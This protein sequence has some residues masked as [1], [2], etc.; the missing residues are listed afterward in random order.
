MINGRWTTDVKQITAHIKVKSTIW[1]C[2][3]DKTPM[4]DGFKFQVLN[5]FWSIVYLG[6]MKFFRH[7]EYYG[8]LGHGCNSSFITLASES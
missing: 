8:S 7:F 5:K 4:P 6:V 1:A 2:G 3:G